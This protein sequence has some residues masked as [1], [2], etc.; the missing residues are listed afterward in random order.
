[1][2]ACVCVWPC[3]YLIANIWWVNGSLG[4]KKKTLDVLHISRKKKLFVPNKNDPQKYTSTKC[5]AQTSDQTTNG[6]A[7]AQTQGRQSDLR[8]RNTT[9]KAHSAPEKSR[10]KE[11]IFKTCHKIRLWTLGQVASWKRWREA[12][13]IMLLMFSDWLQYLQVSSSALLQNWNSF[14]SET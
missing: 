2:C 13:V 11:D 3:V 1:M 6:Q 10:Q 12:V 9:F 14:Q 7:K 8:V 5:Q 4:K